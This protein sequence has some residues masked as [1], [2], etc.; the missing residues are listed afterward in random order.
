VP[1]FSAAYDST[2]RAYA[3]PC[4]ANPF[5]ICQCCPLG[6]DGTVSSVWLERRRMQDRLQ[7]LTQ[8]SG[9][10]MAAVQASCVSLPMPVVLA[11]S[12]LPHLWQEGAQGDLIESARLW[13]A[14]GVLV[15]LQSSFGLLP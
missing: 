7:W 12:A 10:D 5:P 6:R 8:D 3:H 13:Q 1:L 15:G 4:A 2:Y 9:R 11:E 14:V